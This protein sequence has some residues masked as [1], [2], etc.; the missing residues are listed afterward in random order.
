MEKLKV[1][2]HINENE[3]WEVL[4][5]NATNLLKDVGKEG[6]DIAVVANGP[7]VSGY[8]DE[9]KLSAMKDLAEKGAKFIACR[10]SLKKMC[11]GKDG[12]INEEM[13]SAFIQIVPAGIT[14]I[15]RKQ[16]EG[17]AY[18]KP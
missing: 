16:T 6:V 18:V 17:Y 15:A 14:A 11:S 1:L 4:I 9:K 12:C 10:N 2:F 3:R 8:T 5:G 13:L 7:S